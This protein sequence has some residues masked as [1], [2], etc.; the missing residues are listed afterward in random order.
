MTA[1]TRVINGNNVKDFLYSVPVPI[2]TRTYKPLEHK[3]LID[4]VYENLDKNNLSVRNVNFM[5]GNHGNQMFAKFN[6]ESEDS[7]M[8][9]MLGVSNS[10][11]GTISMRCS[12][13]S[14]VF[15]CSNGMLVGD[16]DNIRIKH[17]GTGVSQFK[18]GM[19]RS[20]FEMYNK[21]EHSVKVRDTMKSI[22]MSKEDSASLYGRMYMDGIIKPRQLAILR[23]IHNASGNYKEYDDF[24]FDTAWDSYNHVTEALKK[25]TPL[26]YENSHLKVM[27]SYMNEFSF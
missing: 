3:N 15:I 16:K 21:F 13:G 7:E 8:G 9:M 12:T 27:E 11:D 2:E 17:E 20:I 24:G 14:N 10:Y 25:N 26:N 1:V 6:L 18:R 4:Q 19:E 23:D 22:E 5:S